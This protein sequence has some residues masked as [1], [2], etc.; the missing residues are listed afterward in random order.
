MI[1]KRWLIF[2]VVFVISLT[3]ILS[4]L[5]YFQAKA[6]FHTASKDAETYVL[7]NNLLTKVDDSYVY[8]SSQ[9][10]HT[11][12]GSTK[13]GVEKAFFIPDKK[14]EETIM[15]V[16]LQDGISAEQAIGLAM[17]DEKNSKLL[18]AKL[19]VEE[20][21]PVWEISYINKSN[22]LSY[23]YILFNNGDWWKRISNL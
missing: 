2:I 4:L 11:V 9:T 17:K 22:N 21:G 13:D 5:I 7:K 12:I 1:L 6:P 18:H 20:V 14:T 3:A 8:N 23:V 16:N 15:E 10:I 19:G